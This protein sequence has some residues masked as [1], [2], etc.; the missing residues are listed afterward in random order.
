MELLFKIAQVLK[1]PPSKPLENDE[2]LPSIKREH[3]RRKISG[4]NAPSLLSD[5]SFMHRLGKIILAETDEIFSI[6]ILK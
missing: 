6:A 5:R 1:I 4:G 2:S 3:Y